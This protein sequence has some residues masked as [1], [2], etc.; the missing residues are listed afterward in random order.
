MRK[1]CVGMMTKKM[2]KIM[3]EQK[4]T[5]FWSELCELFGKEKNTQLKIKENEAIVSN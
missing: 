1:K 3:Y 4:P 2:I 5:T